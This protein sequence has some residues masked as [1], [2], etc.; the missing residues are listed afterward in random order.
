MGFGR[1][2][3]TLV[4]LLIVHNLTEYLIYITVKVHNK[5]LDDNISMITQWQPV[6]VGCSRYRAGERS[7]KNENERTME[8]R[9]AVRFCTRGIC[10]GS[11]PSNVPWRQ[12][13]YCVYYYYYYFVKRLRH[14]QSFILPHSFFLWI[15]FLVRNKKKR[16]NIFSVR[17][18]D[19][20]PS[21]L[22]TGVLKVNISQ[23][24]PTTYYV[25][26]IFL[27]ITKIQIFRKND[28]IWINSK[29]N[30]FFSPNV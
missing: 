24:L 20:L 21:Y 3:C 27:L 16:Y 13:R 28:K 8:I 26:H 6:S 5:M 18:V 30:N 9:F 12:T 7:E 2:S 29:T 11:S 22:E 14:V 17:K 23:Y 4:S 19:L 25:I 15:H 10:G 1:V